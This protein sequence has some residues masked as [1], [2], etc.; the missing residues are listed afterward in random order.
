MV[1]SNLLG[2]ICAGGTQYGGKWSQYDSARQAEV[3]ALDWLSGV[4]AQAF[5]V[6]FDA[7][8]HRGVDFR[9]FS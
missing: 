4:G 5:S 6:F 7:M 2:G 3:I 1:A 9:F 8:G